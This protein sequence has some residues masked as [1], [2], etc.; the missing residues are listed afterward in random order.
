MRKQESV[1]GWKNILIE[2]GGGGMGMSFSEGK[3]GK[4]I[5]FEMETKNI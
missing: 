3:I 2:A 5:P 4:E 1:G